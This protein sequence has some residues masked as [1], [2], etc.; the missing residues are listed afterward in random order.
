MPTKDHRAGVAEGIGCAVV[1]VSDTR[2]VD[3]DKSGRFICEALTSAGHRVVSYEVLP[4]DT[5]GIG[6]HLW[7]LVSAADCRAVVLCG[8]TGLSPRDSTFEVVDALLEKRISGFGELF[9][10]LSYA[11]VGPAA[12]LSRAV[13][14]SA[15]STAVFSVPGSPAAVRLAMEKLIL[16]E[17]GHIVHLLGA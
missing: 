6:E 12:M 7:R 15:G 9:R 4:D 16:P 8:G 10:S 3:T 5:E 2:T 17:L 11:E 1:T 14:G 13:A